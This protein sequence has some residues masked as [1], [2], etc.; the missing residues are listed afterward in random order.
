MTRGR[1]TSC[2]RWGVR[3][4]TLL[5]CDP[6]SP[7]HHLVAFFLALMAIRLIYIVA[8]LLL[9]SMIKIWTILLGYYGVLPQ[10][11]HVRWIKSFLQF[12]GLI[13]L[14]LFFSIAVCFLL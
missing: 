9:C 12:D 7:P 3:A 2:L 10:F 8:P 1:T 6:A 4:S 11:L 5:V 13:C 14:E